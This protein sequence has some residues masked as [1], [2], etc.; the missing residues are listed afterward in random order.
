MPI[1]YL[2]SKARIAESLINEMCSANP[3]ADTF[4]DLFGGGGAMSESALKR[5][6]F[7]RVIYNELNA[8]VVNLMRKIQS[9]GIT[10]EFYQWVSREEFNDLKNGDSWRA[11]LIKT[12]WSFGN[13]QRCYLYGKNIEASKKIGHDVIVNRCEVAANLLGISLD[14]IEAP[15][16]NERR[17]KFLKERKRSQRLQH[18]ERLEH[19]EHLQRLQRLQ[20]L[21]TSSYL[22][23]L[24]V[25]NE[26][27]F[28]FNLSAYEKD[29]TI[30]YLD[31]PYQDSSDSIKNSQY[32]NNYI[33]NKHSVDH[34]ASLGF[35]VYLS[36]Y[37]NPNPD[38]WAEVFNIEKRVTLSST[39]NVNKKIERLF[40][41][42]E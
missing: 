39:N 42:K 34:F 26:S 22:N 20:R 27:A 12:C 15:T 41:N 35:T 33:A 25:F 6:Q 14:V 9:E 31:P 7:K 4:I 32:M 28:D 3:Q 37:R 19:L 30:I 13:N 18:L 8:G 40:K 36:E 29:R 23:R 2:G 11:G 1:P 10:S 21:E 24:E 17:L 5:P 38:L 16:I